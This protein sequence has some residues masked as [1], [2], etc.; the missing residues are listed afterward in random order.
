MCLKKV[1]RA[2]RR[3][4]IASVCNVYRVSVNRSCRLVSISKTAY[5][6]KS[7]KRE[8]D[9]EI[10]NYLQKLAKA[11]PRWGFD[12]MMLKIKSE[13][14][15]PPTEVGGLVPGTESPTYRLKPINSLSQNP[16]F[17]LTQSDAPSIPLSSLSSIPLPSHRNTRVPKNAFPSSVF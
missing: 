17:L 13:T 4:L 7:K 5:Y 14:K 12:K 1:S 10:E 16:D 3:E 2:I 6:H 9:I 11:H 8:E 15:Q